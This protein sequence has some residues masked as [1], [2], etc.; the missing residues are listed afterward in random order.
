MMMQSDEEAAASALRQ[1][2]GHLETENQRLRDLVATMRNDRAEYQEL[3]RRE[4]LQ[5]SGR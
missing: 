2:V 1:R 5:C 4:V 3:L